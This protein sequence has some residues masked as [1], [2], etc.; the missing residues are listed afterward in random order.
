MWISRQKSWRHKQRPPS[1]QTVSGLRL[2]DSGTASRGGASWWIWWTVTAATAGAPGGTGSLPVQ[3]QLRTRRW[4]GSE[5]RL[6]SSLFSALTQ[7][8]GA[9]GQ[10]RHLEEYDQEPQIFS[11]SRSRKE[12]PLVSPLC[13]V[14]AWE[15]LTVAAGFRSWPC[16][17]WRRGCPPWGRDWKVVAEPQKTLGFLVSGGDK[18]SIRGQR[19]GLITQ[20]FCAIEFY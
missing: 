4:W 9:P 2:R 16:G 17:P 5:E 15:T 12:G 7:E 14:L 3:G 20:S 1:A 11:C 6:E 10:H 13:R 18:N 8:P 19:R